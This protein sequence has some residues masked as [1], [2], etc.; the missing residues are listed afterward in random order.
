MHTS[1]AASTA[2]CNAYLN[3]I[4]KNIYIKFQNISKVKVKTKYNP[5]AVDP[6]GLVT[7][8]FNCPGCLTFIF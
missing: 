3:S 7:S 2:P 6:A 4:K 5:A 1:H 8:S